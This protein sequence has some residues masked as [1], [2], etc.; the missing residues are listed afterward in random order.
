VQSHHV[1]FGAL[2]FQLNCTLWQ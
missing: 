2:L 1:F